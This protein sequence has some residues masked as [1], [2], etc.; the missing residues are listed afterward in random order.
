MKL[1]VCILIIATVGVCL[2]YSKTQKSAVID[3][4]T[5][6]KELKKLFRTKTNVLILFMSG[7]KENTALLSSFREAA[8]SVKGQGTFILFDCNNS[9]VKKICKKLK[10]QPVPFVI[11]HFKDGDYHKDYDRQLTATSM[12]NFMRDPAGDLPWEEDPIGADVVHVPDAVAL[13]KF[14]KKEVKPVLLMF[15]APWCGFCKTLKPEFSGAA[16]DLKG[17]YVLA[18]IDVNRPENSII[19][20]LYNIT[21]FPTLLYYEYGRMK[22]TFEGENNRQ[23]IVAFMK[24]PTA[25]PT[26]KPKESDWASESNSEIVH[27]TTSNFGPVLKD[28][29][30]ALV[31]FYAP[32]C[33]HCKKMKPEYEKAAEILK[34]K[35]IPG[36]LAA[37]DATIES[38]IGQQFGVKGY[39]TVKYFSNGEFKFDVNVREANKIVEF[40][41]NPIQPPLPP[42]PESSWEDEPSEVVHLNDETFKAFLK[43]KKRVLV[44]F[45]A[46]WCGHC[47]RTKPE[48]N[49]AAE[50]FKEDPRTEL[51]AVDCTRYSAVCS[52]FEVR[53]YPTIKYFNYLK[54]IREYNGGR[55]A[56]DFIKYL[57]DPDA[58]LTKNDEVVEPFGQFPGVDNIL[59]LTDDNVEE[60][61]KREPSLFVMFYVPWCGHCK[62][63]K[64]DFAKIAKLLVDENVPAKVAALDCTVHT[65]AAERFQ[66]RGYPTF[67]YFAK[68]QFLQDYDGKRTTEE[69]MKFLYSV[70]SVVKDEL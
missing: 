70:N 38:S 11:K 36:V 66:I 13:G 54:T 35:A 68:G 15:Y 2:V 32:W 65:K 6:M 23:S 18:A 34:T 62:H 20:K 52:S 59:F 16:T 29:H 48:F 49:R 25:P 40:M 31:M 58:V 61:I 24:N 10:V 63:I 19:R 27:L 26:V 12:V 46:P 43:K 53:G 33:G 22:Y 47:K 14:L 28:E 64:P 21:G 17:R 7:V 45:Y 60:V 51:A 30:S 50:H 37:L 3:S 67:K 57:N 55:T 9:E 4:I 8:E 39:P 69:I 42:A 1:H 5:D 41:Q 56:T 44:I